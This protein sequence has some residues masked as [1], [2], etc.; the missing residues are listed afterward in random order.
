MN[1]TAIVIVVVLVLAISG[2]FFYKMNNSEPIQNSAVDNE[3]STEVESTNEEAKKMSFDA[4]VKQGGSY[5]CTVSQ[6]ISGVE[7]QG[8]VYVDGGKVRGDFEVQSSAMGAAGSPYRMVMTFIVKD[9]YSYSW[10][11]MMP[12]TGYKVAVSSG[13]DGSGTGT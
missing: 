9:G 2:F 4:F 5:E 11:S 3:T 13:G 1:K 8:T 12:N 6:S 10:S 7:S